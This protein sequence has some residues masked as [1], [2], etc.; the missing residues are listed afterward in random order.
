MP[1][2]K[3]DIRKFANG[4]DPLCQCFGS[5][6]YRISLVGGSCVSAKQA[7]KCKFVDVFWPIHL[8]LSGFPQSI[9][10]LKTTYD[11]GKSVRQ[12]CV[13][14]T[15]KIQNIAVYILLLITVFF[16]MC[17]GIPPFSFGIKNTEINLFNCSTNFT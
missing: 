13:L 7:P 1:Q 17:F 5:K 3:W 8:P 14:L 10:D 11:L 12:E 9:S 6:C 4:K 2:L 15:L 16:Y